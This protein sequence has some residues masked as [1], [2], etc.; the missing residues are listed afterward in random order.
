MV[1][2]SAS[3]LL[4]DPTAIIE[5]FKQAMQQQKVKQVVMNRYSDWV[6]FAA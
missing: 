4:R 5:D 1:A 6:A 3:R 2:V